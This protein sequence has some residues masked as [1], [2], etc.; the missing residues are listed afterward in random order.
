MIE[1]RAISVVVLAQTPPKESASECAGPTYKASEVSKRAKITFFPQPALST[2]D[3]RGLVVLKVTLCRTGKVT[4]I[5][6]I[7]KLPHGATEKTIKAAKR[8]DS[9]LPKYT[10]KE[11]PRK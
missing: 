4:N 5:E 1:P 2:S 8:G 9:Y 10:V 3:V 6:V 7:E 11:F